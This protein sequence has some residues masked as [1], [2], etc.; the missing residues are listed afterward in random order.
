MLPEFPFFPGAELEQE[1]LESCTLDRV[2]LERPDH[3]DGRGLASRLVELL[4]RTRNVEVHDDHA[5]SE[6]HGPSKRDIRDCRALHTVTVLRGQRAALR[7][8]C[9]RVRVALRGES[10]QQILDRLIDR[11][12]VLAVGQSR[13]KVGQ[14]GQVGQARLLSQANK[15]NGEQPALLDQTDDSLGIMAEVSSA[16]ERTGREKDER[17]ESTRRD[18]RGSRESEN[19]RFG[20]RMSAADTNENNAYRSAA[21]TCSRRSSRDHRYASRVRRL[22]RYS[23]NAWRTSEARSASERVRTLV[24]RVQGRVQYPPR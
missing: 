20:V 14:S 10:L 5:T 18:L 3:P 9:V 23:S 1:V 21:W 13:P 19:G 22:W 7:G 2:L 15:V 12:G 8:Q 24:G 17:S 4:D 16:R 6:G 11:F